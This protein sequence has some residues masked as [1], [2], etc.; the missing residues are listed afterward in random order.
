MRILAAVVVA[1][2]S[3]LPVTGVVC[4]LECLTPAEVSEHC[5]APEAS[6]TVTI[7]SI[8]PD[9]CTSPFAFSDVAARDRASAAT[10]SSSMMSP[11]LLLPQRALSTNTAQVADARSPLVC[12]GL[13]AGTQLP[14][15]I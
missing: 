7:N 12:P 5:H 1:I 13:S 8:A 3:G 15:R 11:P 2:L 10:S 14:L 9:G 4:G 6:D